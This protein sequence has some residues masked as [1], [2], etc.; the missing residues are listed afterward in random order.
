MNFEKVLKQNTELTEFKILEENMEKNQK[1]EQKY[2]RMNFVLTGR[3]QEMKTLRDMENTTTPSTEPFL[4]IAAA[5][6]PVNFN[7]VKLAS[8]E[9]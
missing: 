6:T 7:R 2:S 1:R 5:R 4:S 8:K 3:L 9:K